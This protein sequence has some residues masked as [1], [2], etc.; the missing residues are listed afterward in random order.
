MAIDYESVASSFDDRYQYQPFK[1]VEARLRS[2]AKRAGIQRVLEVGYGTGHWLET[3][4]DL[5]IGLTGIDRSPAMLQKARER[6][7]RAHLLCGTAEN[8]PLCKDYF[9]LIF[10]V[11]AFHHFSDPRKFVAA[12]RDLLREGGVLAV[13]GLDPHVESTKWYLYDFFADVKA[14]DLSRYMAVRQ[15]KQL[16]RE[17]GFEDVESEIADHIHA[18]FINEGVLTDPFLVRESTSQ[19]LMISDAA[20]SEG[21]RALMSAVEAAKLQ[22]LECHFEVNLNICVTWGTVQGG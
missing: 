4:A 20:Y 7:S 5:N 13:F 11:N 15:V 8:L 19:L 1:G 2:F 18:H 10:C 3:I 6:G 14:M 21:K 17:M 12:S 9:D 16:M 22:N